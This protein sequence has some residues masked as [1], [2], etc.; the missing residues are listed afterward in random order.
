MSIDAVASWYDND[1]PFADSVFSTGVTA[2][3]YRSFFIPGLQ[4]HAGLGIYRTDAGL[5]DSTVVNGL[6]GLRYTF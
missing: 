6:I 3:Y 4:F 1:R 2:G 5:I